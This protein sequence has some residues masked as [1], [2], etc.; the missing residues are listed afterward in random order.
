[1]ERTV[2]HRIILDES[3]IKFALYDYLAKKVH[4]ENMAF[5]I[6]DI[7]LYAGVDED[8]IA[9]NFSAEL[10]VIEKVNK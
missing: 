2:T 5:N 8:Y 1:M 10:K 6:K 4:G 9:F 3:D 7:Q